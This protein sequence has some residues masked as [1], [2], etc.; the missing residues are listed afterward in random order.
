MKYLLDTNTLSEISKADPFPPL[1]E[2]LE[3]Y[4]DETAIS[5]ISIGEMALGIERMQDSKRRRALERTFGFLREDYAG[6]ILDFTE[7][8]AVEWARLVA[9]A[10]KEGRNLSVVDS[11]IEATAVHF[12]LMVVTRNEKDFYHPVLNPWK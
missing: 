8:V 11:Q 5:A 2:W 7:G 6:K 3:S 1:L 10:Q 4:E 12:G 9:A